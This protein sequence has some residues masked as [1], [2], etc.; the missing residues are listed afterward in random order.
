MAIKATGMVKVGN[1]YYKDP[2]IRLV[3]HLTYKGNLTVDAYVHVTNEALG[4]NSNVIQVTV[5][6]YSI[7][8]QNLT[9][10]TIKTDPY[11]DLIKSIETYIISDLSP[12][13]TEVTFTTF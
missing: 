4:M 8:L 11:T 2:E 7:D 13:N 10:P 5:M 6:P 1:A 3:P 12:K 9:Y